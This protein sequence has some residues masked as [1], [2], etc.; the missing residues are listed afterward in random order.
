MSDLTEV[1]RIAREEYEGETYDDLKVEISDA[2]MGE[3]GDLVREHARFVL[4]VREMQDELARVHHWHGKCH[5]CGSDPCQS[6]WSEQRKCCPDCTH[7][8]GSSYRVMAEGS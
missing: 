4:A 7:G 1:L 8:K 3:T 5:E 6:F 2:F